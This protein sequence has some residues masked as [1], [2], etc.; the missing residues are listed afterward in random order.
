MNQARNDGYPDHEWYEDERQLPPSLGVWPLGRTYVHSSDGA[1]NTGSSN[2][3]AAPSS[4]GHGTPSANGH[5]HPS[6]DGYGAPSANGHS[7]NGRGGRPAE[8]GAGWPGGRP[9]LH[10]ADDRGLERDWDDQPS[11]GGAGHIAVPRF[12]GDD[13]GATPLYDRLAAAP[14]ETGRP[15]EGRPALYQVG[16]KYRGDDWPTD[17]GFRRGDLGLEEFLDDAADLDATADRGRRGSRG[18]PGFGGPEP[19]GGGPLRDP[20]SAGRDVRDDPWERLER[21]GA[22]DDLGYGRDGDRGHDPGYGGPDPSYGPSRGRRDDFDTGGRGRRE[23]YEQDDYPPP[24]HGQ[25]PGWGTDTGRRS[26]Q[27]PA[28]AYDAGA[29]VPAPRPERA[30]RAHPDPEPVTQIRPG[31]AAAQAHG[32]RETWERNV[33]PAARVAAV[34]DAKLLAFLHDLIQ[35]VKRIPSLYPRLVFLVV[36]YAA[37]TSLAAAYAEKIPLPITASLVVIPAAGIIFNMGMRYPDWGRRA[38][39]GWIAGVVATIIYDC[40]RLSLVKVGIWGDPIPGIGRL[41]FEDPHANFAWGYLW[42]FAGNGGGMGIAY[43]MLPW[44][45]WKSGVI[46]GTL[47]CTGLAGLLYFFPVAQVHFFP[48]TPITALGGYAGHWVYGAVLGKLTS[49]WL[50]P[51]ELGRI[52][53]R[54]TA[55]LIHPGHRPRGHQEQQAA[56]RAEPRRAAR[57]SA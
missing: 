42:R 20:R 24:A 35:R 37:I 21:L 8:R 12:T 32:Q 56:Y 31:S 2:G 25:G 13:A 17:P 11:V 30:G 44:R 14:A 1:L 43:T 39:V 41:V 23:R 46:Y 16:G 47:I 57:R 19:G 29:G 40:L 49:W 7:A 36:G 22:G 48:L 5:R 51:V 10:P 54:L 55:R 26:Q 50:P 45:G 38:L 15:G 6:P 53:G 18:D 9:G 52:H 27:R 28:A 34:E 33:T 3:H 4:N